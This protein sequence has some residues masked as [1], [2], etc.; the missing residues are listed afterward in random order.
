ME[1]RLALEP[2]WAELAAQLP[3]LL[4]KNL[5]GQLCGPPPP[6]P[7]QDGDLMAMLRRMDSL[8]LK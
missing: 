2:R 5:G 1:K 7:G 3:Q 8:E 6:R 4:A